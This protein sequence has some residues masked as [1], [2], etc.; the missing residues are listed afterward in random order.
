MVLSMGGGAGSGGLDVVAPQHQGAGGG[1]VSLGMLTEFIVQRTY[2]ELSI[3]SELL[4]RKEDME[5]KIEIFNF[6]SRTRML[7]IRLLSLVKWASSASKVDKCGSIINYLERQARIFSETADSMA[8]IARD[9]LPRATLPNFNLPSAVEIL[10]T[11][12]YS[13]VPRIIRDKIVAPEPISCMDKKKTLLKLNQ[14]IEHRLVTSNLPLQ[15]RHL[16]IADGRVTFMVHNEFKASLTLI[17]EGPSVPWR[18]L[19][20]QIL[21]E[22]RDTGEGKALMHSM[23]VR[24]VE[25]LIQTRL[26]DHAPLQDLYNTLHTLC[27]SL[28]LEVLYSQSQKLIRERLGNYIRVEEYRLGK[29]LTVS[30]WREWMS[31]DPASELGYRFSVQTDPNYPGRPHMVVHS[32]VLT[33]EES[34]TAE[35]AMKSDHLSLER[36]LVHSIY[37]RTKSRLRA[38]KTDIEKRLKLNDGHASLHGS[39]AILSVPILQPCLRSEQLIIAIDTHSGIFLVH[40][41]GYESNPYTSEIQRNLNEDKSKLEPLIS[42]LRIWI[43]KNRVH[44]TLQQLPATSYETL[45]ILFDQDKHHPLKDLSPNRM[46]IRLNHHSNAIIIIEFKEKELNQ[47]EMDYSYYFLW[48]KPSSID[49]DDSNR[50]SSNKIVPSVYFKAL[51]MIELD[52]FLV[53]HGP[54]TKVDIQDFSETILGK[55]KIPSKS[56]TPI[57]RTKYPAYFISDLAHV[58][59]FANERIPFIGIIS[60]CDNLNVSHSGI[61]VEENEIGVFMTIIAFPSVSGVSDDEV[62]R[63]RKYL[64]STSIRLQSRQGRSWKVEFIF[65]DNPVTSVQDKNRYPVYFNYDVTIPEQ[66]VVKRILH[67]WEQMAHLYSVVEDLVD[68]LDS[69]ESSE[70]ANIRIKSYNF[71]ELVLEYGPYFKSTVRIKWKAEES[72]FSLIFS[73][74]HEFS[75]TNPHILLRE[76]LTQHLN[77]HRDLPWLG[78]ILHETYPP[79]RSIARLPTTPQMGVTQ[80][81]MSIQTF[82]IIP[83]GP[84]HIKLVFYNS[85]FLDIQIKQGGIVYIRDGAF[86]VFDQRKVVEGAQPIQGLKT[87]LMKYIDESVFHRRQSQTEDDNPPSPMSTDDT[88]NSGLRFNT[89]HTPPSNPMTPASPHT[90]GFLQSPPSS[91]RNPSPASQPVP[92]P[93][94]SSVR[95]PLNHPIGSPFHSSSVPSPLAVGS[96]VTQ[97]PSSKPGYHGSTFTSRALPR[98]LPQRLWAGANPTPLTLNAFDDICKP[99]I[100]IPPNGSGNSPFV[101]TNMSNIS[102]LYRF[103]GC[104]YLK[105]YLLNCIKVEDFLTLLPT[106]EVGII[107]FKVEKLNCRVASWP[108]NSFQSLHLKV[109]PEDGN[110][111][112]PEMLLLLERFFDTKVAA[113]PYRLIMMSSFISILRCPTEVLRDMIQVMKFDLM[114]DL[115]LQNNYKW[116]CRLCLMVPPASPHIMPLGTHG[117]VRMRDKM[118]LYLQFYRAMSQNNQI[119]FSFII[120]VIYDIAVNQTS[121]VQ[122]ESISSGPIV[123]RAFQHTNQFSRSGQLNP[124]RCTILPI[125]HDLLMNF[126]LP[127]EGVMAGGPPPMGPGMMGP[128]MQR[129]PSPM[130]G[131][132]SPY[133][134]QQQQ[135]Q[136]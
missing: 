113:P 30:Y 81:R 19:N 25:H 105:R 119:P 127:N 92:S 70:S 51:S 3:L 111:W 135:Q 130:G 46:Y 49:E 110:Q 88:S 61:E 57:K 107:S 18:L 65:I 28:Q 48:V 134:G 20:V 115:V 102:P 33:K 36:L 112:P 44:K 39:P 91:I 11:G 24:Y 89:P 4:P 15:M 8:K 108:G 31:K 96:P 133:M 95:S 80:Q 124:Q 93:G 34:E 114:P 100:L 7:F 109:Q 94:T 35:K 66:T 79:L 126:T 5:R 13:R 120:P 26:A 29:C 12:S 104:V 43:T 59:A 97:R 21:V 22:D 9:S 68:F 90:V 75:S 118:L 64:L 1:Q 50:E 23:Q 116:T 85:Y 45:P 37:V 128:M 77:E 103:L 2:H 54:G 74:I 6:A 82:S 47:C 58:V 63:L 117:V 129:H 106:N 72:K 98:L 136:Q 78:K 99:S 17:G 53:T 67:E 10:T 83:Q 60:E 73:G 87:F 123:A 42:Q 71:K 40:V 62:S 41:P 122:K 55:R 101:P 56:D 121:V 14:V 32:P 125:I 84:T 38:L 69:S 132:H 86:S 131:Q 27:Q 76:Q 16:H 52:S